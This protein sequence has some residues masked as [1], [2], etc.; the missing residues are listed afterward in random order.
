MT[1][2]LPMLQLRHLQATSGHSRKRAP[3]RPG[4]ARSGGT[5]PRWLWPGI[6]LLSLLSVVIL[7]YQIFNHQA[8]AP[9]ADLDNQRLTALA[10]H[11]QNSGARY[12]GA[13]WCPA[14]QTQ[15]QHFGDAK[16]LLPY[17][18]CSP[19]GRGTP[20]ASV[21]AER[22]IQSFPTWIIAGEYFESVLN[23]EALAQLSGFDWWGYAP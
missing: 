18:E 17:V 12:Y 7:S 8:R 16:A 5:A 11:L 15:S 20:L 1:L 2:L 6:V 13:S 4:T 9:Q 21:C 22:R 10:L 19:G 14:C 23:P 3:T